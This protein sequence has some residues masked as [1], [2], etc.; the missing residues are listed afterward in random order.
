MKRRRSTGGR[1]F[2]RARSGPSEAVAAVRSIVKRVVEALKS[3]AA[4]GI[5]WPVVLLP[6]RVPT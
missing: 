2:Y 5:R 1:S 4:S 3:L 6:I